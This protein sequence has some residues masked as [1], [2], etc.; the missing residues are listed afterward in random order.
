MEV[1][2]HQVDGMNTAHLDLCSIFC[3]Y[4]H[5]MKSLLFMEKRRMMLRIVDG[6]CTVY[7]TVS[8]KYNKLLVLFAGYLDRWQLKEQWAGR[9]RPKSS[10]LS[11]S[12]CLACLLCTGCTDY[13]LYHLS[14]H[15]WCGSGKRITAKPVYWN[16]ILTKLK[17][18]TI[19]PPRGTVE[20]HLEQQH[21]ILFTYSQPAFICVSALPRHSVCQ[22][23]APSLNHTLKLSRLIGRYSQKSDKTTILS[24][25]LSHHQTCCDSFLHI[26]LAPSR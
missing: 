18:F 1:R 5:N 2:K 26:I 17:M 11:R 20:L 23:E 13:R 4:L 12:S 25:R 21:A 3:K 8:E 6:R 10:H 19:D 16:D 24:A 22:Q 9:S 7:G 15:Y 14:S